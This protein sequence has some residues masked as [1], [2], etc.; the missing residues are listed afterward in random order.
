[1]VPIVNES[2]CNG[3]RFHFVLTPQ[4][5]WQGLSGC[6]LEHG[7]GLVVN[8]Y[9][10]CPLLVLEISVN[11]DFLLSLPFTFYLILLVDL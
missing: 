5:M 8:N 2:I 7:H 1:M 3:T 4:T 10:W 11:S 9:P 6:K